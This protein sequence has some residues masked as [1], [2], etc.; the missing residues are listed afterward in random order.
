MQEY[1]IVIIGGGPAGMAAAIEAKKEGINNILIIERENTLGGILNQCIH[2]GFGLETFREDL[3]G[4]EYAQRYIEKIEEMKISF[5]LNTMAIE[6]NKDKILTAVN[7]M[8]GVIKLKA[9]AV[10]LALGC[11][12]RPRGSINI[13]GS[14]C[15]GVFTA[16]TVQKFINIEGVMPGKEVVILGSRD[17]GLIMARRMTIEGSEVKAVIELREYAGGLRKNII[18]CLENFNIPLKL[19]HTIVDIK[20]K[21]RL[22]GVTVAK[23]D[24]EKKI[25]E[26]SKQYIP[27][28]TLILAVGLLPEN[29]L[30]RN[31]NINLSPITRGPIVN[32]SLHTSIDGVFACGNM[33][34]IHDYVD[35]VSKESQ[36]AG[37]CAAKYVKGKVFKDGDISITAEKG[38][39]YA[40]PA[41][42]NSEN[43]HDYIEIKFRVSELFKDKYIS[44]YFDDVRV[45]HKN[46]KNLIP[47]EM[48]TIKLSKEIFNKY[49]DC[50]NITLKIEEE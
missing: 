30:S 24:K 2:T 32:E 9:K 34:H 22:E 18:E 13:L 17:I 15:A 45:L 16:G 25:I 6:F 31:A 28:D 36:I 27:C 38:I 43:V 35:S 49:C 41:R 8:D 10:V 26:G 7:D 33:V 23:V 11:R 20:G 42:I 46:K 14:R 40:V 37:K 5:K 19:S 1:D 4:P 39:K 44:V 3:T 12:E 50:E 29:E 48:E 21:E 47:A